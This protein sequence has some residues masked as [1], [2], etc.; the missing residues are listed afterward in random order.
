MKPTL[1]NRQLAEGLAQTLVPAESETGRPTDEQLGSDL[2]RTLEPAE[3]FEGAF[4]VD[5][6]DEGSEY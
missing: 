1:T 4:V 2:S 5:D 6:E 3:D